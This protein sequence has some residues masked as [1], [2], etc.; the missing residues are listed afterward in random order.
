MSNEKTK[1]TENSLMDDITLLNKI[2]SKD[3][4][5]FQ[6]FVEKYHQLVI[7]ICY[8]VTHNYDDA[9]D[10]SQEVFMK[11]YSSTDQFRG[12]S[13][14]T[15][16]LYRIAVNKSLNHLRSVKRKKWFS[17]LDIIFNNE[18]KSIDIEDDNL[19]PGEDIELEESKKVLHQAL[20]KLPEKQNI[21][22]RLNHFE[23]L[24]YKEIAEVMEISTSEVGV[25][26]NR[27]KKKL[28]NIIIEYYQ[29]N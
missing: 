17:G 29:N 13:K 19:K 24:P 2:A 18:N 15:T 11:V 3:E 20:N 16:W 26:I 22:L 6:L 12:E 1:Q 7:N 28:K 23:D 9:L 5:A 10:I 21:A 27:G 14:V 25:L 8:N 4:N